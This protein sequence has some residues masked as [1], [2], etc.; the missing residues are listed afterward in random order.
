MFRSGKVSAFGSRV[1]KSPCQ[2]RGM[3]V[4]VAGREKVSVCALGV[5][6]VS[7]SG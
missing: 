7:I 2:G 3:E 1:G 5:M 4:F 6:E